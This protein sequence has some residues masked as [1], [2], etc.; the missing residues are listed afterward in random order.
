MILLLEVL[1][2]HVGNIVV[3]DMV[4]S[5]SVPG[6]NEWRKN[7]SGVCRVWVTVCQGKWERRKNDS[8]VCRVWVGGKKHCSRRI[9]S[10][11]H[12]YFL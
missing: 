1:K 6:G 12:K 9:F 5:Y 11:G 4:G 2:A 3:E 10:N 8:A 7:D